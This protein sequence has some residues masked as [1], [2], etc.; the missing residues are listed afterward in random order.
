V[1]GK[2]AF[3]QFPIEE[4]IRQFNQR[5]VNRQIDVCNRPVVLFL[6]I[7]SDPPSPCLV[8]APSASTDNQEGRQIVRRWCGPLLWQ[9]DD[10]AQVLP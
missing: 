1:P 6:T 10:P 4:Q 7:M 5:V 9:L 8:S 3:D 2:A